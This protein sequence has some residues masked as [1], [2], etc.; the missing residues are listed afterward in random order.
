VRVPAT[1]GAPRS[2]RPLWNTPL[3]RHHVGVTVQIT[4]GLPYDIVAFV[5]GQVATGAAPSRDVVIVRAL[6]RER[7]RVVAD[8]DIRVYA[9]TPTP[10]S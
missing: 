9:P 5:D 10:T 2:G 4:V 8:Y 1:I 6:E 7:R 3:L